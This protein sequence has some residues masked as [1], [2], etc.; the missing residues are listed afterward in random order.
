MKTNWIDVIATDSLAMLWNFS[1]G[2]LLPNA[3]A[4]FSW[5]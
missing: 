3:K 4:H 2:L 5:E 1:V